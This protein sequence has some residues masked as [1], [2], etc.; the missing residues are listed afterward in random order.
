MLSL[1]KTITIPNLNRLNILEQQL[2]H[3]RVRKPPWVPRSKA[4]AFRVPPLHVQDIEEELYMKDINRNWKAQMKSIYQ[5]FKTEAKFSDKASAVL[6]GTFF[7]M[8]FIFCLY[9]IKFF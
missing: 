7:L 3:I 6:K 9:E 5:L 1:S 2:R 4:K 8:K